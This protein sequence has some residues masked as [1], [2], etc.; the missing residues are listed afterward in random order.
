VTLPGVCATEVAGDPPGKT[1]EYFEALVLVPKLTDPPA[2][3]VTS[4]SGDVMVPSGGGP[5]YGESWT[6]CALDGTPALSR[7]NSM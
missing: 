6:N 1:Q 4:L 5:A 3:M 7:R 2:G